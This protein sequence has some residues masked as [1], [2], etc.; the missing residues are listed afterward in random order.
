M[1]T[2]KAT[3]PTCG[4]VDLVPD[5]LVVDDDGQSASYT[6]TCPDCYS[7]VTKSAG[8]AIVSL[9]SEAGVEVRRPAPPALPALTYDDVLDFAIRLEQTQDVMAV[10]L[11]SERA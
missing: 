1:T 7:Q 3:C 5:D 9:L 2:I 8:R 11:A 10:L 4:D 6:F